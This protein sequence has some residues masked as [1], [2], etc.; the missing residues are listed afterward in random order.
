MSQ[1]AT[2]SH[3]SRQISVKSSCS[4][5]GGFKKRHFAARKDPLAGALG[6]ILSTGPWRA[7]C[8]GSRATKGNGFLNSGR[9]DKRIPARSKV[10]ADYCVRANSLQAP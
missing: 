9:R 1:V 6:F 5:V 10:F 8:V 2:L 3:E 4:K 7:H